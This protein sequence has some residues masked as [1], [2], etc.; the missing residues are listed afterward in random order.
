MTFSLSAEL[1]G[2]KKL[3]MAGPVQRSM[4]GEMANLTRAKAVLESS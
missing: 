3:L 2:F 1:S 4:D